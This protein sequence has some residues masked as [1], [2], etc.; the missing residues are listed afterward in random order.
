[1]LQQRGFNNMLGGF[2]GTAQTRVASR[3]ASTHGACEDDD[4]TH[5]Y[6][7]GRHRRLI[8]QAQS[9]VFCG[10][11]S[12]DGEQFM[13][14]TQDGTISIISDLNTS[15]PRTRQYGVRDVGWAI[16]VRYLMTVIR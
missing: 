13:S 8:S 11:Y 5:R 1:M 12:E 15:S 7:P 6:V 9:R 10:L 2:E 16:V 4:I 3:L 14:A